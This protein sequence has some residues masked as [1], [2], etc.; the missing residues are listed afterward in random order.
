MLTIGAF[1]FIFPVA[2]AFL[3]MAQLSLPYQLSFKF[4]ASDD[5]YADQ[6][7][8]NSIAPL[9]PTGTDGAIAFGKSLI[10]ITSRYDISYKGNAY[11]RPMRFVLIDNISARTSYEDAL[12]VVN[13]LY[14]HSDGNAKSMLAELRQ[15]LHENL[16]LFSDGVEIVGP[17]DGSTAGST[18]MT[19]VYHVVPEIQIW[20][21]EYITMAPYVYEKLYENT[22]LVTAGIFNLTK[23]NLVLY[24]IW[25]PERSGPKLSA[26]ID[27]DASMNDRIVAICDGSLLMSNNISQSRCHSLYFFMTDFD[28]AF[29]IS[30]DLGLSM[31]AGSTLLPSGLFMVCGLFSS[32]LIYLMIVVTLIASLALRLTTRFL[33]QYVLK[34]LD[35]RRVAENSVSLVSIL[36]AALF[37]ALYCILARG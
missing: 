31:L 37:S 5:T 28:P 32:I 4:T 17:E 27:R 36:G 24:P 18:Q 6:V 15:G 8:I 2:L 11:H 30:K 19:I 34:Y 22:Q 29:K 26:S 20:R 25:Q 1:T 12:V 7:A 21:P 33:P 9:L 10:Q 16:S 13:A 14:G 35:V 23:M 3:Y